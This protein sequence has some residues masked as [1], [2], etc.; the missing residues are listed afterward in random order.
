MK[1]KDFDFRI[2]DKEY[3]KADTLTHIL[4]RFSA[5]DILV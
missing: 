5:L 2:A 4:Y 1:L 3:K